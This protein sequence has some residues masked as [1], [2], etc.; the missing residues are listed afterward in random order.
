[1][2]RLQ[3]L[4]EELSDSEGRHFE[5]DCLKRSRGSPLEQKYIGFNALLFS[6]VLFVA[7]F[8]LPSLDSNLE[9]PNFESI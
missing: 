5:L 6:S 4:H 9:F 1:M 2:K 3:T 7:H 8:G